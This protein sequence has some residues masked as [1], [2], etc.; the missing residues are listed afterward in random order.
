MGLLGYSDRNRRAAVADDSRSERVLPWRDLVDGRVMDQ[1]DHLLLMGRNR[2][3]GRVRRAADVILE[4]EAA[5]L[6]VALAAVREIEVLVLVRVVHDRD[7]DVE[8]LVLL[9]R[10]LCGSHLIDERD[11]RSRDGR[12]SRSVRR[13]GHSR[14]RS[15]R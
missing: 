8:L 10:R 15:S 11:I 7:V 13:C 3:E 14:S 2:E 12:G 9:V 1:L 4:V 6:V 5:D